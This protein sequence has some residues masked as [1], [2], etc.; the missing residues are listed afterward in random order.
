KAKLQED[1]G[2]G[3]IRDEDVLSAALYPKVFNDYMMFRDEF[4][5]VDGLPTRLFFTGPEIGEEF[6]VAI[7]PGKVLNIKVLAISN[8]HPNGQREVFC[9]MNGQLRT[10]MVEDKSVTKTLARHPKADKSVKGSVG[11]PMPGKVVGIRVKE[12]EVVKKGSPLVVLSAMKMET[13]VSAPID[14]TVNKISVKLN[15]TLEAGDLL[16]D[17]EPLS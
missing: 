1:F 17:I 8:L 15:Q 6:Q 14:G 16:V 11:A 7:E 13:N 2:E 10:V 9:E 5:P 12:K 3:A 4:G